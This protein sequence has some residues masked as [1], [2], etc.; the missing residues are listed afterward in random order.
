[1]T[2]QDITLRIAS[3]AT[4]ARHERDASAHDAEDELRADFIRHV[5][6]GSSEHAEM[7]RMI[8]STDDIA[9]SRWTD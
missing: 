8:L 5:S 3:I 4:L 2:S 1:M 6:N 9:F 7:A